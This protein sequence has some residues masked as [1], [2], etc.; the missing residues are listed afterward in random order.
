MEKS[1]SSH[2]LL[3][4]LLLPGQ[5]PDLPL[6]APLLAPEL[7]LPL[8]DQVFWVRGLPEVV[9]DELHFWGKCSFVSSGFF[10]SLCCFGL[11]LSAAVDVDMIYALGA[12]GRKNDDGRTW[13]ERRRFF[14]ERETLGK[15]SEATTVMI[16]SNL[17]ALRSSL[18]FHQ[19]SEGKKTLSLS[20]SR[21]LSLSLARERKRREAALAS[22]PSS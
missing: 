8:P 3:R 16:K 13:R 9:E 2:V 11:R 1:H 19:N 5:V 4:Q 22:S 10:F 7:R 21:L 15:A 17:I 14:S 20:L 18:S 6:H 12:E